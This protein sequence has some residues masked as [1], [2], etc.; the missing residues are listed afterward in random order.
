[1]STV[2][3]YL[4][5]SATVWGPSMLAFT[6][7]AKAADRKASESFPGPF[8]CW[9]FEEGVTKQ[10]GCPGTDNPS[11]SACPVCSHQCVP[12]HLASSGPGTLIQHPD[13]Q[14]G[15]RQQE[16][17]W[18]G[19]SHANL[20]TVTVTALFITTALVWPPG[21]GVTF[22]TLEAQSPS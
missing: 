22:L 5:D 2:T 17:T 14:A 7:S 10:P 1:M 6:L 16:M 8:F 21:A 19:L 20:G 4:E 18:F 11:A 9:C 3:C 15:D 13:P 12:W